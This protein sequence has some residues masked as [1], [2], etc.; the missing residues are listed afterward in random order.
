MVLHTPTVR[1]NEPFRSIR[2]V[3]SGCAGAFAD[4]PGGSRCRRSRISARGS[5]DSIRTHAPSAGCMDG[6]VHS[7]RAPGWLTLGDELPMNLCDWTSLATLVTLVWPN[8][9]SYERAYFW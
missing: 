7:R 2:P 4:R 5:P 3:A 1:V 6:V 9:K 8:Q